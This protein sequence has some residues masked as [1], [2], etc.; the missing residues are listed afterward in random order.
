M[1][2]LSAFRRICI[3]GCTA[4]L[5]VGCSA[6]TSNYVHIDSSYDPTVYA[7]IPYTGPLFADV[8]GIPFGIPQDELQRVVND[9]IQPPGAKAE[10][11]QG[12]RV[13]FAFGQG[14][15]DRQ[16]A[17]SMGGSNTLGSS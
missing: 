1:S 14:S 10:T 17:C 9:I 16:S 2:P 4:A 12:V 15:A 11:G 13:H 8:S 6:G 7:R 5:L 3:T